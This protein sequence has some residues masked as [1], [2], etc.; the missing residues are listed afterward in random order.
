MRCILVG[1]ESGRARKPVQ[2]A[3]GMRTY[4]RL[5]CSIA[6]MKWTCCLTATHHAG[7]VGM[8]LYCYPM[9]KPCQSEPN[10]SKGLGAG[11]CSRDRPRPTLRPMDPTG[12]GLRRVMRVALPVRACCLSKKPKKATGEC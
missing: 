9:G 10:G 12:K 2:P 1:S 4:H 11:G 7:E 3:L 6:C 8:C 5:R